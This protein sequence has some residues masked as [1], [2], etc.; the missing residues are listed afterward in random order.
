VI[1]PTDPTEMAL[2]DA[3]LMRIWGLINA[4]WDNIESLLYDAF[5]SMI[6]D[7]EFIT[8]AIFYSQKSHA[9]RR[10]MVESL[11]KVFFRGDAAKYA[12]LKNAIN[13]V[14]ARS[15]SRNELAH[16]DWA[17][18]LKA[19]VGEVV[20]VVRVTQKPSMNDTLNSAYDKA[21]LKRVADEMADTAKALRE[22]ILSY[23]VAK[24][25]KWNAIMMARQIARG[26]PQAP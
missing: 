18:R 1:E 9:A 4:E 17:A 26:G 19:G 16:G 10:D 6:D 24:D 20:H 13:R 3:E 25:Q 5:D 7:S 11:A 8:R 12:P 2:D 21:D 23:K 22:A 14:K 15:N